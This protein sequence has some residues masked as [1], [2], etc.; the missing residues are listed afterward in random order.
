MSMNQCGE[1]RCGLRTRTP[2]YVR[3]LSHPPWLNLH[4]P[5][6]CEVNIPLA[7]DIPLQN[8]QLCVPICCSDAVRRLSHHAQGEILLPVKGLWK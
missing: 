5:L 3:P 8:P 6:F 1:L 2:D 7:M 4:E